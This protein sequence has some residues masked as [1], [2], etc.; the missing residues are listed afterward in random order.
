MRYF[1]MKAVC[2]GDWSKNSGIVLGFH[3]I[4]EETRREMEKNTILEDAL[5]QANRASK[6]K[7]Y[8]SP[9]C[10]TISAPR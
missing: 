8:S 6:A 10:H 2:A 5:Q 7:V 4:D 1:Q 9:I 3:S